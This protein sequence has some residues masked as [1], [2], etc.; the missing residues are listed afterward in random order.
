[1]GS[2]TN[3]NT[4]AGSW[5]VGNFTRTAGALS[6]SA[7]ALV[8][9]NL[10]NNFYVVGVQLELGSVATPYEILP[11]G[12]QLESCQRYYARMSSISGGNVAFGAGCNTSL[13]NSLIYIKYPQRMR[14]APTVGGNSVTVFDGAN[15]SINSSIQYVGTDS[16]LDSRNLVSVTGATGKGCIFYGTSASAYVDLDAEL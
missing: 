16:L 8:A 13:T 10:T 14:A 12:K 9:S 4:T 5:Q 11:Y 6:F 3:Y 1:M 15:R 2:G 7:Q